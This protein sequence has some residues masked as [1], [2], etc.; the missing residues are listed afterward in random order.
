MHSVLRICWAAQAAVVACC[1]LW[2]CGR[3]QTPYFSWI[4]SAECLFLR[5]ASHHKQQFSVTPKWVCTLLTFVQE[6][7]DQNHGI[8]NVMWGLSATVSSNSRYAVLQLDQLTSF[9]ES[10]LI[11]SKLKGQHGVTKC[12]FCQHHA[13]RQIAKALLIWIS[14]SLPLSVIFYT[15]LLVCV[16]EMQLRVK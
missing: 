15:V 7:R 9:H 11:D 8:F 3:N 6:L 1:R 2:V 14:D 16:H 4:W 13:L 12:S 5:N 10:S